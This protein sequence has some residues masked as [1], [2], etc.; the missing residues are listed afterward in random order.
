MKTTPFV[1]NC[2]PWSGICS[3]DCLRW[4][5]I[6]G[7]ARELRRANKALNIK[8]SPADAALRDAL[9]PDVLA[10]RLHLP[11]ERLEHLGD[12]ATRIEPGRDIHRRRAVLIDEGVGQHHRS[13]FQSAFQ[14]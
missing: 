13:H 2:R 5:A 8:Y 10:H 6:G 1:G 9:S 7:D 3:S 14:C 4:S 12:D 11:A